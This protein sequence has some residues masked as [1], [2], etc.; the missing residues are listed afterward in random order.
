MLFMPNYPVETRRLLLRPFLRGDVD[1]VYAYRAREDV[2][3]FLTEAPMSRE[4]CAEAVRARVGWTLWNEQCDRIFLAVERRADGAMIGE[5]SLMLRDAEARQ[6]E[7]G[8][9]LNPD[10]HGRGYATEAAAALVAL[11]FGV[12]GL[13]RVFARCH[14]DN[15]GSR[16]VMER[17]GMRQEAHFIE[18]RLLKGRWDEELVYAVLQSEWRGPAVA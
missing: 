10:S 16:R 17:L 7:I 13:H 6:G 18:H 4:A 9:V 2:A 5:V 14:P 15:I 1:A 3:R 11:G 12:A 8:Y